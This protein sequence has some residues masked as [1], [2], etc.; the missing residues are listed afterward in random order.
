VRYRTRSRVPR[1]P[2][3]LAT[4]IST[5]MNAGVLTP[6]E[7]RDL[8]SDIFNKEF[9]DLEGIWSKLPTKL[10]LAMLQ[11]KNQLVAAA[12]LGSETEHDII[13]RLQAALVGQLE[14]APPAPAQPAGLAAN[15][16]SRD[17]DEQSSKAEPS[18]VT[19][20]S[21]SVGGAGSKGTLPVP[22]LPKDKAS[23]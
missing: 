21:Q 7:G 15:P 2:N 3:Q 6:D 8:A 17:S 12:L 13:A 4:I 1:E 20:K 14:G 11:T 22:V 9:K 16:S 19:G 5:L 10:L 23:E 18:G